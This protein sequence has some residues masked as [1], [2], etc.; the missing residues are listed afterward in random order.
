MD[1]DRNIL[2]RTKRA[3]TCKELVGAPLFF[4]VF[5]EDDR[6]KWNDGE[7]AAFRRILN[8]SL[9]MLGQ[10]AAENLVAL[11]SK[12][13]YIVMDLGIS[14]NLNDLR[15]LQD[16]LNQLEGVAGD[17]E[18]RSKL[19]TSQLADQ[20]AILFVYR[21]IPDVSVVQTAAAK[22]QF[23]ETNFDME[24]EA[25]L[26]YWNT[27]A[28]SDD[29]Y[30]GEMVLL[31]NILKLFGAVDLLYPSKVTEAA[32]VQMPDSVMLHQGGKIDDL[33]RYLIGWTDILTPQARAVLEAAESYTGQDL[34][35]ERERAFT[36]GNVTNRNINMG[37][38]RVEGFTGFL[39]HGVPYEGR[40][41]FRYADGTVYTGEIKNGFKHGNGTAV[42]PD[43]SEI[44]GEWK[45][46]V[47]D[48]KAALR[49]A[50][51]V[52]ITGTFAAG[53]LQGKATVRDPQGNETTA[54]FKDNQPVS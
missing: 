37:A 54:F 30:A 31:R 46:D 24:N 21:N 42:C 4:V 51:G 48:G 22:K 5:L 29:A 16:D 14:D 7:I 3:G 50:E 41:I 12:A 35:E 44:S 32:G 1:L 25:A 18:L 47:P 43:G 2:T 23:P 13:G 39:L 6:S 36:T 52:I 20:L 10:A 9:T 40:G 49:T 34:E 27:G 15:M 53:M 45:N 19:M 26:I 17:Y 33:T 8:S 38:E 11:Q 28:E